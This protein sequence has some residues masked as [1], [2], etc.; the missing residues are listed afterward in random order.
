MAKHTTRAEHPIAAVVTHWFHVV[1]LAVLIVTGFWLHN[2]YADWSYGT[3][4]HIHLWAAFFLV[5][6]GIFRV[7]WAFFGSGSSDVGS[8]TK[9]K[10]YHWFFPEKENRGK[11]LEMLKY[12]L[13]LRKTHPCTAK[14]NPLQKGAYIMLGVAIL[15]DATTGLALWHVTAGWF[16]PAVYWVGGLTAVR[17]MHYFAMWLF[18]LITSAHVYLTLVEAPWEIPLIFW[19]KENEEVRI[20]CIDDSP[21]ARK[22]AERTARSSAGR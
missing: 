5:G 16:E 8:G 11:T 4:R 12:Y 19:W 21:R 2:P 13:F 14:Y 1:A 7:Y 6:T 3:V 15:I 10:D 17:Q 22:A 20:E 9:V 18:I